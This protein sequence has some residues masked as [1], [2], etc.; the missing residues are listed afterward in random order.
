MDEL[1]IA[2]LTLPKQLIDLLLRQKKIIDKQNEMLSHFFNK[3]KRK[4][5]NDLI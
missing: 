4:I 5:K 1:N 3:S 2:K